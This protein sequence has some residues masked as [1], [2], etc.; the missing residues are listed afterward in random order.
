MRQLA[1][2][3]AAF[4]VAVAVVFAKCKETGYTMYSLFS[5]TIC[6]DS[7][8]LQYPGQRESPLSGPAAYKSSVSA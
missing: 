4:P 5:Y 6:Q 7:T 3:A 8:M 2:A 1:V